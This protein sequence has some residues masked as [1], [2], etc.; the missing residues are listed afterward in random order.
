[1]LARSGSAVITENKQP[2]FGD[3]T[4]GHDNETR[5]G[6][7]NK[8]TLTGLFMAVIVLTL[9]L[10]SV[11]YINAAAASAGAKR[12]CVL[13]QFLLP[14]ENSGKPLHSVAAAAAACVYIMG[15]R[16]GLIRYHTPSWMRACCSASL[17]SLRLDLT[18]CLRS[19]C[20]P[21]GVTIC[22]LRC[23]PRRPSRSLICLAQPQGDVAA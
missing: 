22:P 12:R 15:L 21:A 5:Q 17:A 11:Q 2:I 6:C 9:L 20:L 7:R 1:M 16:G 14:A 13:H 10:A 18:A 8:P 19:A 23:C 4:A 3:P